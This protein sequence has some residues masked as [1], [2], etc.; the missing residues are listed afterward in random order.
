MK[1]RR[2]VSF[3]G[4]NILGFIPSDNV[5]EPNLVETGEEGECSEDEGRNNPL[6]LAESLEEGWL[7]FSLVSAQYLPLHQFS[8]RLCAPAW[9]PSSF[10]QPQV[11][12][13]QRQPGL[14]RYAVSGHHRHRSLCPWPG[15]QQSSLATAVQIALWCRLCSRKVS[16]TEKNRKEVNDSVRR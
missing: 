3:T 10:R 4:E 1:A 14:A 6:P 16:F 15:E 11:G 7:L 8:K 5:G 2:V 9:P 12:L 13:E